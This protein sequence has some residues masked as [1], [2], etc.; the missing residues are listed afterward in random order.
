MFQP[1]K[2][3]APREVRNL[4]TLD[5]GMIFTRKWFLQGEYEWPSSEGARLEFERSLDQTSPKV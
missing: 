5:E 1:T 4:H 2:R 3:P